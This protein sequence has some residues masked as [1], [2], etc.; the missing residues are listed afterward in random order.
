MR[1]FVF[2]LLLSTAHAIETIN[3][4]RFDKVDPMTDKTTTSAIGRIELSAVHAFFIAFDCT[5]GRF[6]ILAID[7]RAPKGAP[8][9]TVRLRFGTAEPM[10]VDWIGL[11][12]GM[13]VFGSETALEIVNKIKAQPTERVVIEIIDG[14]PMALTFNNLAEVDRVTSVCGV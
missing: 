1:F 7:D 6:S 12:G 9:P 10:T 8:K 13:G 4:T 11:G 5:D 2:F 3:L 14:R